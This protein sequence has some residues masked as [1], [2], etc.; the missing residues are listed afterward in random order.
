MAL[1]CSLIGETGDL[2]IRDA[3]LV[4]AHQF[5]LLIYH[6]L[7][8]IVKAMLMITSVVADSYRQQQYCKC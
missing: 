3:P 8:P 6:G 2:S 5:H 7:H 1:A 4:V